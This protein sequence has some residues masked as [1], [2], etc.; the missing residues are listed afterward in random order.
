MNVSN[1]KRLSHVVRGGIIGGQYGR[2]SP[3]VLLELLGEI[4]ALPDVEQPEALAKLAYEAHRSAIA[5][6]KLPP[7]E[8]LPSIAWH[9][10]REVARAVAR[11]LPSRE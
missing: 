2:A 1:L 6:E 9:A 7:W 3:T 8:E 11:A 5:G 10:W 4:D